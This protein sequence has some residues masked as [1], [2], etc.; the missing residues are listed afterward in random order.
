MLCRWEA[1]T[2]SFHPRRPWPVGPQWGCFTALGSPHPGRCPPEPL[3]EPQALAG[4]WRTR[5]SISGDLRHQRGPQAQR[6][7]ARLLGLGIRR[8]SGAALTTS[9]A[10]G[11]R[12]L[13]PHW[14]EAWAP[15][16][17]AS[18]PDAVLGALHCPLVTAQTQLHHPGRAPPALPLRVR[19]PP[20]DRPSCC[21]LRSSCRK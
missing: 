11:S 21:D 6:Q 12:Q 1:L 15:G 17:A 14:P 20:C 2:G 16:S 19:T 9:P 5:G 13:T 4:S 3:C 7:Q 10:R 8:S 18:E